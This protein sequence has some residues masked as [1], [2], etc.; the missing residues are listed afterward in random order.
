VQ[1]GGVARRI[2]AREFTAVLRELLILRKTVLRYINVVLLQTSQSGACNS[3]HS[4]RQRLARWLLVAC[5]GLESADL[6]L[7]HEVL[8]QLLGIRRA[9]VTEGL[10]AF[11][12]E[13][14]IRIAR[15]I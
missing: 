11:E 14:S 12:R 6:P 4:V 13:G 8:A 1:V 9:S 5:N 3:V 15:A 10:D 7:T 2:P